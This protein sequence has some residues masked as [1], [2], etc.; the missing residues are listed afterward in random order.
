MFILFKFIL[1]DYIPNE[2]ECFLKNNKSNSL[3]FKK[4]LGILS[5]EPSLPINQ[6][7]CFDIT[8]SLPEMEISTNSV[9]K[10][11]ILKSKGSNK[12]TLDPP[13]KEIKKRTSFKDK[14]IEVKEVENFKD[15]NY[16]HTYNIEEEQMCRCNCIVN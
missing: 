10:S 4:T 5:S 8:K 3:N 9:F 7:D 1:E 14:L 11:S 16:D 2:E 12:F 13:R 15:F 6:Q